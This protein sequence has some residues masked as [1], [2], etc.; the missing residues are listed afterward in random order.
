[1]YVPPAWPGMEDRMEE[2]IKAKLRRA[3]IEKIEKECQVVYTLVET[4]KLLDKSTDGRAQFG[5]LKFY[6]DWA[7]HTELDRSGAKEFVAQLDRWLSSLLK[8]PGATPMEHAEIER[9]LYF[10]TFRSELRSF[11]GAQ[12]LPT[13][14]CEGETWNRFIALYKQVIM[15]CPLTYK[16]SNST[17]THVDKVVFTAAEGGADAVPPVFVAIPFGINI[18]LFRQ[19]VSHGV[20]HLRENGKLVGIKLTIQEGTGSR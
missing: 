3:L 19:E 16:G 6:C 15:D 14:V 2:A 7:V 13:D 17:L 18:E 4:R 20:L 5:S 10:E 1:M 9:L 12:D 11:L 8:D